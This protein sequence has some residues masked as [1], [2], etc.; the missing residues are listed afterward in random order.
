VTTE[1]TY[2]GDNNL[3]SERQI[4]N[5]ILLGGRDNLSGH[6]TG[7]PE[8]VSGISNEWTIENGVASI[9]LADSSAW[10]GFGTKDVFGVQE[11][12]TYK[13]SV[14][15]R[16]D[17]DYQYNL[18]G[19]PAFLPGFLVLDANHERS[20]HVIAWQQLNS[21]PLSDGWMRVEYEFTGQAGEA[22]ARPWLYRRASLSGNG[23]LQVRNLTVEGLGPGTGSATAQNDFLDFI[24]HGRDALTSSQEGPP[25]AL[26]NDW[27]IA[28]GV[29]T[30][31]IDQGGWQLYLRRLSRAALCR[32]RSHSEWSR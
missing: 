9:D 2:D 24:A 1:R 15:F 17:G 8:A 28:N 3:V 14:E 6:H 16:V 20:T 12:E 21:A 11:G 29:G 27:T 23:T 32:H 25:A 22:Y 18:D 31:Q 10:A 13:L 7:T 26:S 4:T 30:I 5:D 19:G